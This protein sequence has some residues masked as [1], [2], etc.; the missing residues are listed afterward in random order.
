M[1]RIYLYGPWIA[2]VLVGIFLRFFLADTRPELNGDEVFFAVEWSA[3]FSGEPHHL[4]ITP[5]DRP[6]EILNLLIGF[7]TYQL[8]SFTKSLWAVRLPNLLFS[9]LFIYLSWIFSR[10]ISSRTFSFIFILS[11]SV[12][13]GLLSLARI[14]IGAEL[15]PFFSLLQLYLAWHKRSWLLLFSFLPSVLYHPTTLFALPFYLLVITR[16]LPARTMLDLSKRVLSSSKL[17]LFFL[18]TITFSLSLATYPPVS[19]FLSA[20]IH[21]L[22]VF[23]HPANLTSN[24]NVLQVYLIEHLS[25]TIILGP[26]RLLSGILFYRHIGTIYQTSDEFPILVAGLILL[27]IPLVLSVFYRSNIC[28]LIIRLYTGLVLSVWL[29]VHL[30]GT[31]GFEANTYRFTSWLIVPSLF[32]T[33]FV[34]ADLFTR[35]MPP[36]VRRLAIYFALLLTTYLTIAFFNYGIAFS[37]VSQ[38]GVLRPIDPLSRRDTVYSQVYK[39]LQDISVERRETVNAVTDDYFIYYP[40]R[41]YDIHHNPR[42]LRLDYFR[43]DLLKTAEGRTHRDVLLDSTIVQEMLEDAIV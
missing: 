30:S 12:C 27:A 17:P 3:L 43:S 7:T 10:R 11:V 34:Y 15:V 33:S 29:L 35:A 18:G 21:D 37:A 40:L 8:S 13:P 25:P 4:F 5:S 16:D 20:L 14:S 26:F 32:T 23:L 22:K 38:D 19:R 31:V 42:F 39:S 41:Y 1:N 28:G 2:C 24:L 9:V 36:Q 6:T